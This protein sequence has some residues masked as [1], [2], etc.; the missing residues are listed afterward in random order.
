MRRDFSGTIARLGSDEFT[1]K[2]RADGEFINGR[3][4]RPVD[5]DT[6]FPATG[7]VQVMTPRELQIL[8]EATRARETRKLYTTC[9]LKTGGADAP[10]GKEPDHIV[11]QGTEYEVQAVGDWK[12][13]GNYFKYLLVKA[14]Q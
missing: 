3:Y 2:R 11:Y 7:S 6:E 14:G 10:K 4:E 1:V 5:A 13:Q 12:R 8:P 9:E